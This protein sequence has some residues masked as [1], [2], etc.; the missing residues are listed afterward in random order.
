MTGVIGHRQVTDAYLAAL[1]RHHRG[2]LATFD[3]GP[4]HAPPRCRFDGGAARLA[5]A[6]QSGPPGTG[7]TT[8][9]RTLRCRTPLG[10]PI[11][12]A[13]A[14]GSCH[15]HLRPRPVP[16]ACP[17]KRLRCLATVQPTTVVRVT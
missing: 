3:P 12:R 14:R 5:V 10:L 17:E 7:R 13:G 8:L 15:P 11:D 16:A 9:P 1:A 2:Q 4:G 6:I